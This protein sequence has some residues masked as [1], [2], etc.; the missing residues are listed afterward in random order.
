MSPRSS[1]KRGAEGPAPVAD[2]YT[3]LLALSVG[4][5]LTGL[6]FLYFELE[7]YGWALPG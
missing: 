1:K 7:K 3:G 6:V 2:V 5:I 4:A